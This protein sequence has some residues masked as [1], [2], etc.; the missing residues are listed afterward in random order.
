MLHWCITGVRG[1]VLWRPYSKYCRLCG[2]H[3]LCY[4]CSTLSLYHE[5]LHGLLKWMVIG[6]LQY[7]YI[8]ENKNQ[9]RISPCAIVCSSLFYGKSLDSSGSEEWCSIQIVDFSLHLL[10][11]LETQIYIH[12]SCSCNYLNIS[13]TLFSLSPLYWSFF[14]APL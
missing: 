9:T 4:N 10:L 12:Y 14:W 7:S 3:S 8:Y 6:M 2:P 11:N 1:C 5:S 13:R